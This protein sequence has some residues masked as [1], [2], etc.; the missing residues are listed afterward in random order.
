MPATEEEQTP[1]IAGA[2]DTKRREAMPSPFL[3]A[4]AVAVLAGGAALDKVP[5]AHP[6]SMAAGVVFHAGWLQRQ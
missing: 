4:D 2:G 5:R 6:S 1:T 3:H